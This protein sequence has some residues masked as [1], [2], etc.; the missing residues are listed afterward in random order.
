MDLRLSR[1]LALA[2]I[3]PKT[4]TYHCAISNQTNERILWEQAQ[5]H[6]NGI[7]ECLQAV[8]LLASIDNEKEDRRVLGR[9][10]QAVLDGRAAGVQLGW[11][12]FSRNVLVVG[13]ELI[14]LKTEWAYPDTCAHIN[15][16]GHCQL[17]L[18]IVYFM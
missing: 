13:R 17:N 1:M 4:L 9:V 11:N 6:N 7:L 16:A 15:L 5:A 8:L 3:Y 18:V 12:L 2:N 10:G 14:S